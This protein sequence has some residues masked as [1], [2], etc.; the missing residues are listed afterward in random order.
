MD[1][2]LDPVKAVEE[3]WR[4]TKGY[5]WKVFWL[6]LLAIP[7]CI[8]GVICLGIG[9]IIAGMWISATYVTL[10]HAVL[11][12]KGEAGNEVSNSEIIS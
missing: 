12:A 6:V 9:L 3:N 2:K 1:K 5:G 11:D 10:Y 8:L 7:I 4:L